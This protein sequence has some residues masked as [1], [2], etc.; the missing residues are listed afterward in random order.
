[1]LSSFT[2]WLLSLENDRVYKSARVIES[3]V[4][5]KSTMTNMLCIDL[6]DNYCDLSFSTWHNYDDRIY[7]T[8]KVILDLLDKHN[9]RA[10]F[11]TV[12]YIAERYP[13]LIEQ[14]KSKGHEIASHS[15]S[16]TNILT[17][18]RQSFELDFIKSKE[19]LEKVTGEQILGFR[20]PYF[21]IGNSSWIS[22]FLKKH[23]R[24]DS[25]IFPVAPHYK[26]SAAPRFIYRMSDES[27]FQED[28]SSNLIEIPMATIHLPIIG[29]IPI[30]GG[31]YMRF[32]PYKL[33]SWGINQINK[34]GYSAMI[35]VH[36]EDLHLTRAHLPGYSWHYFYGLKAAKKKFE[37]LLRDFKFSSVREV[38]KI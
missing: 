7:L 38:L 19:I 32:F 13:Q 6:E 12:G 31:F 4:S 10:T 30:A 17:M 20:A 18:D 8:T 5:K 35:Y 22:K 36:P 1:M 24:Y 2:L 26:S 25:S 29:S 37:A 16:H 15:Y 23:L 9:V 14:I 21:S 11:F 28:L 3:V 27:P 33:L 34:S